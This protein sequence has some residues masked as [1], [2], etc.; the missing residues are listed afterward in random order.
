MSICVRLCGEAARELIDAKLQASEQLA[1]TSLAD[2]FWLL[3]AMA[4]WTPDRQ[5][6][7]CSLQNGGS[8]LNTGETLQTAAVGF[9]ARHGKHMW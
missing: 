9:T 3:A 7:T 1:Q 6:S 4:W 5:E 2:D 8:K